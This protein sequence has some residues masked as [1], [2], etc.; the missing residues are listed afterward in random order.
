VLVSL[1]RI[2]I[3][4]RNA[5]YGRVAGDGLLCQRAIGLVKEQRL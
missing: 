1:K 2:E 3:G 5:F 4:R